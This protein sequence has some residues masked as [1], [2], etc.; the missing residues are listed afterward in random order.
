M[1]WETGNQVEHGTYI[2]A[3]FSTE[4]FCRKTCKR[5]QFRIIQYTIKLSLW[6]TVIHIVNSLWNRFL[7]LVF[8]LNSKAPFQDVFTL[9]RD[10]LWKHEFNRKKLWRWKR[11]EW[12]RAEHVV[13]WQEFTF[14]VSWRLSCWN[15]VAA[16]TNLKRKTVR[17]Q[18]TRH[19]TGI[20][21]EEE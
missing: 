8:L 20:K 14:L 1:G 17:W 11:G 4:D 7:L 12:V 9:L 15:G 16:G 10:A 13:F 6:C 21:N 18:S 5:K 3:S 2:T 19:G